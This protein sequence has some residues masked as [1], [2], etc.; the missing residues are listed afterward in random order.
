MNIL[1]LNSGSS[2]LKFRLYKMPSEELLVEGQYKNYAKNS[3]LLEYR[4]NDHHV[5]TNEISKS[6]WDNRSVLLLNLLKNLQVS[7]DLITH[8]VVHGG[9]RYTKP[10]LATD[11]VLKALD[12]I[13]ELAPLHNPKEIEIVKEIKK[14]NPS[15][16][17]YLVFDTAFHSTMKEKTYLYGLPYKY[18]EKYKIRRYGFH[19]IS[20]K[21]VTDEVSS[22][23]NKNIT[24]G[25]GES[26]LLKNTFTSLSATPSSFDKLR[27]TEGED[28]SLRIISCH[29]GSGSSITAIKDGKSIDTSMGFSPTENL[30]MATRVGEI[31][32][33]AVQYLQSMLH[34]DANEIDRILNQESGLLGISGYTNDMKQL[35]KDYNTNRFARLAIDMYVYMIQ[36]FIGSY[37]VVLGGV[38]ALVFTAGIGAGSDVIREKICGGLTPLGITIEKGKNDNQI[39]VMT[40]LEITDNNSK[41][42]VWIIPTNEELQMARE[43]SSLA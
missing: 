27:I 30:I 31:D 38:D 32:Y 12:Q 18:Y 1:A 6:D 41:S 8:R 36:K 3:F 11:D 29:L 5:K 17:Q 16:K 4:L 7:F 34:V 22:L 23:L 24:E 39:D 35:L 37:F 9:E 14:S 25:L 2:S 42:K 21:Y 43:V 15:I 28:N 20:H 40:N 33:D 13:S 10:T 26:P 19:G